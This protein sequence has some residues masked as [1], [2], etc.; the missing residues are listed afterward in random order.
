MTELGARYRDSITGFTGVAT[1]RTEYLAGHVMVQLTRGDAHAK[2]EE[3]WFSE[4]RLLA[5]D[6]VA[7]TG[8]YA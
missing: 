4:K 8:V 7:P 6:E 3:L 1:A 5:R 2:P